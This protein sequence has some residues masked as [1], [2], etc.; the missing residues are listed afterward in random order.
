MG[1]GA[2]RRPRSAGDLLA[3]ALATFGGA[4]LAPLAPGTFGAAAGVLVFALLRPSGWAALLAGTA[5]VTAVGIWAAQRACVLTGRPDDGRVVIDEVAGQ[6]LA[7]APL[8]PA[9]A[10]GPSRGAFFAWVVTGFVAFRVFDIAK[11]GPVRWAERRFEGGVGVMADDV[12]AGAL[13]AVVL[14]A[15]RLA[16]ELWGG[17]SL[18][19]CPSPFGGFA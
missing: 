1:D 13:A 7:L 18:A 4:G 15:L 14:A 16:V 17:P 9:A 10:S 5:V 19:A 11:P 6:L 8:W 3:L 12:V 2:P